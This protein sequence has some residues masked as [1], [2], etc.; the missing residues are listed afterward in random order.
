MLDCWALSFA[1]SEQHLARW[2]RDRGRVGT[3]HKHR[4]GLYWDHCLRSLHHASISRSDPPMTNNLDIDLWLYGSRARGDADG[5]SD[6]DVLVIADEGRAGDGW[7]SG[8]EH[9]SVSH[10]LQDIALRL[11]VLDHV[12]RDGRRLD[13]KGCAAR[14]F[15]ALLSDLPPYRR[16]RS[17]LHGFK[18]AIADC[19]QSVADGGWPDYELEVAVTV[20]RHAALLGCYCAGCPDYGREATFSTIGGVLGYPE[21]VVRRFQTSY[22]KHRR[23]AR[24]RPDPVA[25]SQEVPAVL[26]LADRLLA[27]LEEVITGYER[28]PE[29]TSC[30]S[31]GQ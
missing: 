2:H 8:Y 22:R 18:V 23:G 21:S 7:I 9:A 30:D 24:H 1:K 29:T 28:A 11:A 12:K 5:E 31:R 14:R 17:D 4:G 10:S 25:C 16:A 6:T 19:R 20:M 26:D 3:C 13:S 27:D 15:D